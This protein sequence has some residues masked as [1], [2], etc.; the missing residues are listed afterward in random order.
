MLIDRFH[1]VYM[2]SL[3]FLSIFGSSASAQLILN[4][5]FE[6]PGLIGNAGPGRQQYSAPTLG[7]TGWTVSGMGDVFLHKAPDIG[8]D[9]GSQFN[10]A[11]DGN[12]YLDLSGSYQNSAHAIVFQDFATVP[13]TSYELAF[14][15]GASHQQPPSATINVQL[16]GSATLLDTTL[17]PLAPSANINWSH[18][19]FSFVAD[20]TTT[21]LSFV[22]ISTFDDNTS[23]VDNVSVTV[24]PEPSS[25]VLLF[26]GAL[27]LRAVGRRR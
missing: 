11:Q 15:I 2:C 1:F 19:T 3:F 27:G 4:G 14:Y 10:F 20:S 26:V 25:V 16:T 18:Q 7:L 6:S 12:F 24:V 8:L 5:S 17:T 13:F 21:R 22:D 9:A 23:F